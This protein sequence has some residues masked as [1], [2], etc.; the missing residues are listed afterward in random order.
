MKPANLATLMGQ[1]APRSCLL[2]LGLQMSTTAPGIL[3]GFWGSESGVALTLSPAQFSF[4]LITNG[5]KDVLY[6]S[7]V[8][9]LSLLS[10]DAQSLRQHCKHFTF[11]I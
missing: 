9:P 10:A 6:P 8:P 4:L 3:Y 7:L 11:V 1:K 5:I 2:V